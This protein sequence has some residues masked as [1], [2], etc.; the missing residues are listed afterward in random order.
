V[1][2]TWNGSSNSIVNTTETIDISKYIP[3]GCLRIRYHE[4]F[5]NQWRDLNDVWQT[6][7]SNTAHISP[8]F[9][10]L[11]ACHGLQ[12]EQIYEVGLHALV[13][14]K[15][16]KIQ[17]KINTA[18]RLWAQLRVYILPD[19]VGRSQIDRKHPTLRAHRQRLIPYLDAHS[20]TWEGSWNIDVPIVHLDSQD[21]SS[22]I[23]LFQMFNT[24]PSPSPEPNIIQDIYA[25][26]AMEQLLDGTLDG[27][28]TELHPYQRKTA[29]LMLQ[30]E[31]QPTQILDPRLKKVSDLNGRIWYV[32][33]ATGSC[34][35]EERTYEGPRGGIC[36][37]TMGLGK[38]LI[39]L[40][41]I[42][43][44]RDLSS[45]VPVE[46]SVGT[47]THR[48][49][50]GSLLEMAASAIGRLGVPWKSRVRQ[51][52]EDQGY[53]LD[54]CREALHKAP[55]HYY[56]PGPQP[57]RSSRK[58]IYIPPRKIQL[59]TATVV[60]VPA[61]L[62][63]QWL[64]EIKKHTVDLNVLIMKS[65]KKDLPPAEELSTYDLILF[66]RQ[67]FDQEWKDGADRYGR[68]APVGSC[69]CSYIGA[70]RTKDCN[71]FQADQVYYSPLKDLHFKRLI[72][73]EG[74]TMGSSTKTSKTRAVVVIDTLQI[75]S[76]WV[77]SGTPTQGL[78]GADVDLAN[79]P[80][81]SMSENHVEQERKDLEKLGNIA[82]T[83]LKARPWSNGRDE[84]PAA[85]SEYVM[86]PRHGS[87]SRGSMECLRATL[88]SMIIR[89]RPQDVEKDIELPPLH[90]RLVYLEGSVQDRISIN[91]FSLMITSNA[92]TSERKDADYLFH[93]RQRKALG[94]LV[95]NLRQASF[96]WSGFTTHSIEQTLDIAQ[97]FLDTGAIP[98]SDAD[99]ILLCTAID[100]GKAVLKSE[101]ARVAME[102]HEMPMYVE[103]KFPKPARE[104]WALD[105]C[106]T[107]P[108]L[109]GAT[110]IRAAQRYVGS[111]SWETD[112]MDEIF[113]AG[114]EAKEKALAI[115]DKQ[116]EPK[117]VIS[118]KRTA[119]IAK[120]MREEELASGLAGGVSVGERSGPPKQPQKSTKNLKN[121]SAPSAKSTDKDSNSQID[122]TATPKQVDPNHPLASTFIVS[123][124][125]AKLSY[126]IDNVHK[127]QKEEKMIIF[128]EAEDVAYYIAQA[129][130]A[131]N[132][133]HL[134]YAKS[135]T[136]ERRSHYIVTFNETEKFRVLLMDISQAA[137][138]LNISSASRVYF[139]NPVFNPQVEAQAVKRAHRIG[140]TKP[141]YV[142]TLILKGTLEEQIIERR[143]NMSNDEH[144]KCKSLLDDQDM[145]DW[146]RESR[147]LP[148][149]TQKHGPEQMA[150]L[151]IPQPLFGASSGVVHGYH[152][153]NAHIMTEPQS[154]VSCQ[155]N[156]GK[157][158]DTTTTMAS[159]QDSTDSEEVTTQR[160][161]IKRKAVSFVVIDDD[162]NIT[163]ETLKKAR[164]LPN[165]TAESSSSSES[166]LL[167]H[168]L[169]DTEI[170]SISNV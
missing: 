108:T 94:S 142:E 143:K 23:S 127:H 165:Q 20:V 26:T 121:A 144:Q 37:E 11:A 157:G 80:Q 153:G 58:P 163:E 17:Y 98:I 32:D 12:T 141:V 130:E 135:L 136:T 72:A 99:R 5:S 128:Y 132:V 7:D 86:Q 93:P 8:L 125:S 30:R 88:E 40:A 35:R 83:Y 120:M 27:L 162:G 64:H 36:A 161:H 118:A 146:I 95:T 16:I 76:R 137:F 60:V 91:L 90:Q 159:M 24:L 34:L 114:A 160:T 47:E 156:K 145:Y 151:K 2:T 148:L 68:R 45:H 66:S 85:W 46:Y 112:P 84:D 149:G 69:Q 51:F 62:V 79:G 138:G 133:E 59:S 31:I 152:E 71:C 106:G 9:M 124:S 119:K 73:D 109:F 102:L 122:S 155:Q 56:I 6:A 52:E 49:S 18:D 139:V 39:C 22:D 65:S 140:Q 131:I 170:R 103:N 3:A 77:V 81:F 107:N 28:T 104:I 29:A 67:R 105:G 97:K 113:G 164:H 74:H 13:A 1:D 100:A 53:S 14:S 116:S 61:N 169:A 154:P 4:T 44:T 19:D 63:Q 25:R 110:Q 41:L 78:Y 158:R 87:K 82:V 15:W 134:I 167:T 33:T 75:S 96:F 126:L 43:A 57:R 92:I 48:R 115:K 150:K 117:F 123:T 166:L 38:T 55:G 168:T 10:M 111:H 50:T 129:L 147:F 70:S 21:K 101:I 54:R 42:L 89:H